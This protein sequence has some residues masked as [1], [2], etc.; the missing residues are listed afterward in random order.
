MPSHLTS[1]S[2]PPTAVPLPQDLAGSYDFAAPMLLELGG[3]NF[4]C[5]WWDSPDDPRSLPQALEHLTDQVIERL[6]VGPGDRVLDLGCGVG[7]PAV[8][9]AEVT[10]AEVLGV[11]VVPSHVQQATRQAAEAGLSDR[12]RFE[13][14]DAHHLS[15]PEASFD[16]VVAIESLGHMDRSVVLPAVCR[17][18]RP[19]GRLVAH[20]YFLHA[21]TGEALRTV[22]AAYRT[23]AELSDYPEPQQLTAWVAEAGLQLLEFRDVTQQTAVPTFAHFRQLFEEIAPRLTERYSEETLG[24]YLQFFDSSRAC[25]GPHHYAQV[26]ARRPTDG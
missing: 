5:G 4:H 15:Y 21:A 25:G 23:I 7:V 19:G 18:L 2:R 1:E 14:A 9:I 24:G 22:A 3:G 26:V 6:Q 16:A 12:V 20:D 11:S 13:V 10:G 8:R 17:V